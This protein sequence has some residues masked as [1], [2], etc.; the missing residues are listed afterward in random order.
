MTPTEESLTALWTQALGAA[1]E[2]V[3][4]EFFA[5]GGTSL[6]LVQLLAGVE[7][8]WGVE[9]PLDRLFAE[10]FSV[11]GAAAALDESLLG[12]LSAEELEVLQA[13]LD[14]MSEDEVSAL[15]GD[16]EA[17]SGQQA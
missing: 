13:E 14:G 1:P 6:A 8:A 3:D 5:A 10:G 9:L 4:T 11:R 12:G 16:A 15:L 2:S 17:P 7:D